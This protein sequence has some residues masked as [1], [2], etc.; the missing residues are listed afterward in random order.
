MRASEL[1]TEEIPPIRPS[2]SC[3]KAFNWMDE[4]KVSHIPV[5]ENGEY[6]GVISDDNILDLEDPEVT[7]SEAMSMLPQPHVTQDQHVYEVMKLVSDNGLTV[8]PILNKDGGYLGCTTM[9]H[10]MRLITNTASVSQKGGVLVL[11][12]NQVDYSLAEISRIVEENDAKVLSS[13]IT[14]SADSTVIEVTLKINKEDLAA[15]R[16]TFS[17]YEYIISAAYE[18]SNYEEDMRLRYEALMKYLNM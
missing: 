11:E 4:F 8:V 13:N 6:I 15:I 5:V 2:E 9:L 18:E 14:S 12:M 17:R 16:Q 1:I 10:L 3:M 7:I